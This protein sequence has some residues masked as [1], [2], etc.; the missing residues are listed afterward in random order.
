MVRSAPAKRSVLSR[1][2]GVVGELLLTGGIVVFLF[3]VWQLWWT[4][5]MAS[6]EQSQ[7]LSEFYERTEGEGDSPGVLAPEYRSDPPSADSNA[8]RDGID[9]NTIWAVLHVPAFGDDFQV[10]IA[11]GVDLKKVLD[12]GSL[13]HYPETQL[14]GELG[15]FAVAGHRQSYG[16]PLRH[17]P[18]LPI[19]SPLIVE[20]A[21]T[22]YVYRVT[23]HEIVAPSATEVLAPVPNQLGAPPNGHF[24]TLTTC[25][26]PFVSNMRWVTFAEL[27]YWAPRSE[28][29]PKEML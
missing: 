5:V 28:G 18:S 23:D 21:D 25:H 6:R 10:G 9:T 12:R 14:P 15:N 4:D 19:G 3:L 17:Q 13:G 16:A 27:D 29:T 1:V 11:E 8:I 2:L 24:M 22:Y 7:L 26:P 20:T